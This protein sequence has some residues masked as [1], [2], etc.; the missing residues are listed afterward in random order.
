MMK[1][2]VDSSVKSWWISVQF[3]S[4]ARK[5]VKGVL[6][7]RQFMMEVTTVFVSYQDSRAPEVEVVRREVDRQPKAE[8]QRNKHYRLFMD[9]IERVRV[10]LSLVI[11]RLQTDVSDSDDETN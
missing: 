5:I 7:T 8:S 10:I 4:V 3:F 11:E 2:V 9:R 1:A 6:A